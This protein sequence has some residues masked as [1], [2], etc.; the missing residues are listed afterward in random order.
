MFLPVL[1]S[2]QEEPFH[3]EDDSAALKSDLEEQTTDLKREVCIIIPY[4]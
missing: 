1:K 4:L 3:D 2:Y